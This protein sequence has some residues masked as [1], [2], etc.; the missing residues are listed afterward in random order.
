MTGWHPD[1][2][3]GEVRALHPDQVDQAV[4]IPGLAGDL[5]SR[6]FQQPRYALAQQHIVIGQHN[7]H[8]TAGVARPMPSPPTRS[9]PR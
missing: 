5:E 1:V 6:P 9:S 2:E 4:R 7:P 3:H 8:R